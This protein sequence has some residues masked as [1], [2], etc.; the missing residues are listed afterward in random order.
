[1]VLALL[2][3]GCHGSPPPPVEPPGNATS[4]APR[5]PG[6]AVDPPP[7]LPEATSEAA[8]GVNVAVL[9]APSD[10]ALALGVIRQFFRAVVE[11]SP[12]ALDALISED[13]RATIGGSGHVPVRS[14]WRARLVRLDYRLLQNSV[15]FRESQVETYQALGGMPPRRRAGPLPVTVEGDD[16][17]LRVP[18]STPRAGTTRLFGDEMWFL[19]K[20]G[21]NGYR[22]AQL[23][24]NFQ[25][26]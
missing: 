12:Q 8:T 19:L 3:G 13:A 10:V 16:V 26:P 11:E 1:M 6:V 20:P 25:L 17:L 22:I 23:V 24:E 9:Q 15:V 7:R 21:P 14:F 18:I 5:A 4:T 2:A